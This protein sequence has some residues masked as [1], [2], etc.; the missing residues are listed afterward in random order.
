MRDLIL[1][2]LYITSG[3]PNSESALQRLRSALEAYPESR[4]DLQIINLRTEPLR[5]LEDGI[6][7]VPTLQLSVGSFRAR[8]IGDM[9]EAERLQQ[10]LSSFQ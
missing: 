8:L 7:A 10:F 3:T 4:Y 2:R 5:A 9:S 6:V 1:L